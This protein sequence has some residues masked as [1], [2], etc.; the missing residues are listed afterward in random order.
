MTQQYEYVYMYVRFTTEPV[1]FTSP[2]SLIYTHVGTY[3]RTAG[4]QWQYT[5]AYPQTKQPTP[6]QIDEL[7]PAAA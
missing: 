1:Y 4:E 2:Y 7:T 6:A 5:A 3:C